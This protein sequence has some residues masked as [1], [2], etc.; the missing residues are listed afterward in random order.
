MKKQNILKVKILKS[1]LAT[2]IILALVIAGFNYGY[3]DRAAPAVAE[4]ISCSGIFMKT[5]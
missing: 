1:I 5:G 3:V 2:Y 4:F